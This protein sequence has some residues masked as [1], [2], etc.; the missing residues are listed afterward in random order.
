MSGKRFCNWCTTR[1][2]VPEPQLSN[3]EDRWSACPP[4]DHGSSRL[5]EDDFRTR[6][7]RAR[8]SWTRTRS[9]RFLKRI[10]RLTLGLAFQLPKPR[11]RVPT[12]IVV[13][14]LP[15]V[16][17]RPDSIPRITALRRSHAPVVARAPR[18]GGPDVSSDA[19][20]HG[21]VMAAPRP[22]CL[23]TADGTPVVD[24]VRKNP[25]RSKREVVGV[26]LTDHAK[27]LFYTT[28]TRHDRVCCGPGPQGRDGI[29]PAGTSTCSRFSVP[30][31]PGDLDSI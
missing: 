23:P 17:A 18:R 27:R 1:W 6:L 29:R 2:F 15:V 14:E 13:N 3:V 30:L 28:R 25:P 5:D 12:R 22:A 4:A 26:A 19:D 7:N 16:L 9:A 24:A 20:T 21:F 8:R 31:R 11:D 10:E